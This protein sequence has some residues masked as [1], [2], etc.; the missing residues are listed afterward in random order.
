MKEVGIILASG[1]KESKADKAVESLKEGL[2]KR[3]ILA[4]VIFVNTYEHKSL[5]DFEDGMDMA[6]I[7]GPGK[8][9]TNLPVIQGLGLIYPWLG[10]EELFREILALSDKSK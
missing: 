3:E 4:N 10:L 5:L 7:A 8:V 2:R 9:A 6:V 1:V